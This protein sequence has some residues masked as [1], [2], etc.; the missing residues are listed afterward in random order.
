MNVDVFLF[1]YSQ[2]DEVLGEHRGGMFGLFRIRRTP[3]VLM[4]ETC[5]NQRYVPFEQLFP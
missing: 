5:G 3:A 1:D 4:L 2:E